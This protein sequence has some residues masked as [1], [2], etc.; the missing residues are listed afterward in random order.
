MNKL[1]FISRVPKDIDLGFVK[2][3]SYKEKIF[4]W[5]KLI[6]NFKIIER[7]IDNDIQKKYVIKFQD[8]TYVIE[9]LLGKNF[10]KSQLE[11]YE[12]IFVLSDKY[13][14]VSKFAQ[15]CSKSILYQELKSESL[16]QKILDINADINQLR[17]INEIKTDLEF[18]FIFFEQ[19]IISN[20]QFDIL[21]NKTNIYNNFFD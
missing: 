20:L 2:G 7:I 18:Q 3:L 13:F 6:S 19:N 21:T 11:I 8:T 9:C 1:N 17:N 12:G 10:N 4:Y 15:L 14:L 16:F 5:Y